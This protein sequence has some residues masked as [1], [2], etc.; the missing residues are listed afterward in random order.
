MSQEKPLDWTVEKRVGGVVAFIPWDIVY[1][2]GLAVE[3]ANHP[4]N[5][6]PHQ[7]LDRVDRFTGA[8]TEAWKS[9]DDYAKRFG[10]DR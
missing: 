4:R 5:P 2:L 7:E 6:K 8:I 1:R 9:T 3:H 10:G